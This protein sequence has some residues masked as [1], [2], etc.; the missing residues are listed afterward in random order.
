MIVNLVCLGSCDVLTNGVL[1][2]S[3]LTRGDTNTT[4]LVTR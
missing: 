2:V 1:T 4:Y 3:V